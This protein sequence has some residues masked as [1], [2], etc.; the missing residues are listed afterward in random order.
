MFFYLNHS[1]DPTGTHFLLSLTNTTPPT[2][3]GTIR[4]N[5]LDSSSSSFRYKLGRLAILKPYR[6]Y[7]L[8]KVLVERLHEWVVDDARVPRGKPH[9]NSTGDDS[10]DIEII[11][12]SQIPV[13]GFYSKFGYQPE[14]SLLITAGVCVYAHLLFVCSGNRI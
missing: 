2:P 1:Y 11:C 13:K 12:H 14:V 7:G 9:R 4:V 6:K 8:G 3:I 5:I 10:K